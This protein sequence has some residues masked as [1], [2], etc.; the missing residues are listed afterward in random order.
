[1]TVRV[2]FVSKKVVVVRLPGVVMALGNDSTTAPVV[3][4]AVTWFVVPVTDDT[5]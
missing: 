1:M 5:G 4:D 3:G 2:P